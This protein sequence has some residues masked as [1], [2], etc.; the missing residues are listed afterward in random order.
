LQ[1]WLAPFGAAIFPLQKDP[2]IIEQVEKIY[3]NVKRVTKIFVDESGSIGRRYARMD[4]V[5]TPFCI[6]VDFDTVD[7]NSEKYNTVTVRNRDTK[8]QE[9]M[10]ISELAEFLGSKTSFVE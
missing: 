6:T 9:R 5:G 3:E 2:K 4:E 7:N 8:Y 1:P 10:K